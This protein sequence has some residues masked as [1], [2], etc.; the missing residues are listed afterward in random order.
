MITDL[1]V[2]SIA[3]IAMKTNKSIAETFANANVIVIVDTSGSMDTCDSRGGKSRYHVAKE[4][5]KIIQETNPGKIAVISF[6]HDVQFCPTGVPI[7]FG[8][9]TC[10][11][12]ALKF[13]K[14]ADLPGNKFILI[15]DGEPNDQ[16]L[17]LAAAKKY[18]QK[19]HVIYVGPEEEQYG[20]DF[21][22]KLAAVT[23]GQSISADRAKDLG[24]GLQ[25]FLTAGK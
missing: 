21:L 17:A 1:V 15:S 20:R 22:A 6:S 23:G 13:A 18:R 5:L 25:L 9:G 19:I 4:E 2:G 8:E 7:F 11:D 10:L 12:K 14:I 3:D 24:Q 16:E